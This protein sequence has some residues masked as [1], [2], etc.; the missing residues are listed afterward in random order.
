VLRGKARNNLA[1]DAS[2]QRIGLVG[3]VEARERQDSDHLIRRLCHHQFLRVSRHD[4]VSA[5]IEKSVYQD[6][7][8][9][10]DTSED[11]RSIPKDLTPELTRRRPGRVGSDWPDPGGRVE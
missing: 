6:G 5:S 11:N 4:V 9:N 2:S 1:L 3:G 7:P 10:K 8:A